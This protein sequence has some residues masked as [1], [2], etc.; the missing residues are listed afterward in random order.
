MSDEAVPDMIKT[1]L[2]AEMLAQLF[3]DLTACARIEHVQVRATEEGGMVD[4]GATLAET[5]QLF[6]SGHASMAQIRYR[7][8]GDTWCDTLMARDGRVRLVRLRQE[9]GGGDSD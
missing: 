7:F 1:E 3:D 9:F 8:E 4:R 5:R 2:D 6:E